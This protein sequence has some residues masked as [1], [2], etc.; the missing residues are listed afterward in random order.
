MC[1]YARGSI[2]MGTWAIWKIVILDNSRDWNA[3]HYTSIHRQNAVSI[4]CLRLRKIPHNVL[5]H[6][7]PFITSAIYEH[8]IWANNSYI[9]WWSSKH[10]RLKNLSYDRSQKSTSYSLVHM[11]WS[12]LLHMFVCVWICA[13]T[14]VMLTY[15]F[16]MEFMTK[17]REAKSWHAW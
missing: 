9:Y 15:D 8:Y 4:V 13:N 3:K 5:R 16:N 14:G 11:V 6:E 7:L 2:C 17:A 10:G 1:M 12:K